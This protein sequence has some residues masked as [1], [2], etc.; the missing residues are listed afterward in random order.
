MGNPIPATPGTLPGVCWSVISFGPLAGAGSASCLGRMGTDRKRLDA[1]EE[2]AKTHEN[3][4]D[5]SRFC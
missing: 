4:R 3:L 5:H 2:G 1:D